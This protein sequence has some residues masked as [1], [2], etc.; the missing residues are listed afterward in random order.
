MRCDKRHQA[1]DSIFG[2]EHIKSHCLCSVLPATKRELRWTVPFVKSCTVP[3]DSTASAALS[4]PVTVLQTVRIFQTFNI[5]L[6]PFVILEY[7]SSVPHEFSHIVDWR[8]TLYGLPYGFWFFF[9]SSSTRT[10]LSKLLH[11]S[12]LAATSSWLVFFFNSMLQ[13]DASLQGCWAAKWQLSSTK[14]IISGKLRCGDI[15]S[16]IINRW[17]FIAKMTLW[18]F[19]PSWIPWRILKVYLQLMNIDFHFVET[20]VKSILQDGVTVFIWWIC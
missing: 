13:H 20:T 10:L 15:G 19:S 3:A 17:N 16:G 4:W 14:S 6:H 9:S 12:S 5:K 1:D 18:C 11:Q 8:L 2:S 7:P